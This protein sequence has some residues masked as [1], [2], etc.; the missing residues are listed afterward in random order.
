MKK[1]LIFL[2]LFFASSAL[3]QSAKVLVCGPGNLAAAKSTDSTLAKFYSD[4]IDISDTI[5]EEIN[6]YEAVFIM[7]P[8]HQLSFRE[9]KMLQNYLRPDKKLYVE[10][11]YGTFSPVNIDTS[12]LWEHVGVLHVGMMNKEYFIQK[13][14]GI[15]NSFADGISF[16]NPLYNQ[17]SPSVSAGLY[18]LGKVKPLLKSY[19]PVDDSL[20]VSYYYE[21]DSFKVVLQ[22]IAIPDS[23]TEFLHRILCNYFGLC[24]PASVKQNSD[25]LSEEVS[26]FPNPTHGVLHILGNYGLQSAELYSSKGSLI[27]KF[28]LD[29]NKSEFDL[30]L[31]NLSSGNYLL[32]LN[33][34]KNIYSKLVNVIK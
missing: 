10:Y 34:G 26:L 29:G 19:A 27:S 20:T 13:V 30:G 6:K 1:L 4:R 31:N 25:D 8:W 33:D 12:G 17:G 23:N 22:W 2:A 18:L 7:I 24:T 32:R 11:G 28:S 5:T 21:T 14:I 15:K 3:A 9:G 16:F